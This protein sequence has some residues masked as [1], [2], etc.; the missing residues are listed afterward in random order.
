MTGTTRRWRLADLPLLALIV[1]APV[2]TGRTM[3]KFMDASGMVDLAVALAFFVAFALFEGAFLVWITRRAPSSVAPRAAS[4]FALRIQSQVALQVATHGAVIWLVVLAID[5]LAF[6]PDRGAAGAAFTFHWPVVAFLAQLAIVYTISIAWWRCLSLM[7]N[8][9]DLGA[10]LGDTFNERRIAI[11]AARETVA[12]ALDRHVERLMSKMTPRF[13]RM[14]YQANIAVVRTGLDARRS[15]ALTW[16]LLPVRVTVTLAA[17]GAAAAE[18]CVRCELR[19]G[20]HRLEL[21]PNP[22]VVQSVLRYLET[23]LIEPLSGEVSLAVALRKQAELRHQATESQLR[24][25]QAQI[26]PHFL[27]NTLASVRHLYRS[28]N[29][30][31]ERMMDHVI[32]YLRCAMQELRSDVSTV[33]KEM[34]LALHYLAIMKIRMGERLSYS[35]IHCDDVAGRAF[36]PA[37]LISL[38]ENAIKHGLNNSADGKLTISAAR[39]ER[40]LRVTVLDNGPGFSS[41]EGTGVGLSNIRQ[42]LEAI[43]GSH[44]WLEVGAL[45]KGGFVASIVV[46]FPDGDTAARSRATSWQS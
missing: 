16:A 3:G 8:G 29:D 45:A 36:P 14:F 34:D 39:E 12:L 40:H 41:V 15:Y 11:P 32:A 25:L 18:L 19:G 46:P 6:A 31:G 7:R 44:A 9:A 2:L 43:Y 17:T 10:L 35:F 26:E 38:V 22:S 28:S 1:M 13:S 30:C 20:I 24:I 4:A 23:N 21:F 42:R 27:F 5:E 33:G 37:M